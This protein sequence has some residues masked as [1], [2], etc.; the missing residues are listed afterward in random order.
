MNQIDIEPVRVDVLQRGDFD[1]DEDFATYL[2]QN[3]PAAIIHN[4]F[5]NNVLLGQIVSRLKV[6]GDVVQ[7]LTVKR[8]KEIHRLLK[9]HIDFQNELC[10]YDPG[11]DDQDVDEGNAGNDVDWKAKG[12]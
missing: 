11:Y 9:E 2:Q 6:I 1:S 3:W 8:L 12:H 7:D 5:V 4:L 10:G